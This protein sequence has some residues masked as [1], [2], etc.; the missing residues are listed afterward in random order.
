[1]PV[2]TWESEKHRSK[3]MPIKCFQNLVA[4]DG[5]LSWESQASGVRVGGL[6]CRLVMTR[7]RDHACM[8]EYGTLDAELEVQRTIKRAELT[9]SKGIVD[10]L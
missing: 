7:R 8:G 3:G 2:R 5:A 6:L 9:A 10:G 4:T 1:M